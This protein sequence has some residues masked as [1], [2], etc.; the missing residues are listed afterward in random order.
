MARPFTETDT[1]LGKY[2]AFSD[3]YLLRGSDHED[4]G[5]LRH[6][7]WPQEE[8]RLGRGHHLGKCADLLVI[9]GRDQ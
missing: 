6:H 4:D 9:R 7:N 1:D 5:I 2:V 3:S 8:Q